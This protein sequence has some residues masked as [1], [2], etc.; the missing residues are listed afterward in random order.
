[1]NLLITLSKA[2]FIILILRLEIIKCVQDSV[3]SSIF[4][5]TK[6]MRFLRCLESF[7][8]K[9]CIYLFFLNE[10]LFQNEISKFYFFLNL[11]FFILKIINKK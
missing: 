9:S 2:I 1:M 4:T 6:E 11:L 5:A 8:F 10:K 7:S 3:E